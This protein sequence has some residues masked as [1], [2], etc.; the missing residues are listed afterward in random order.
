MDIK[1]MIYYAVASFVLIL[2]SI[3]VLIYVLSYRKRNPA[4]ESELDKATISILEKGNLPLLEKRIEVLVNQIREEAHGLWAAL[5][6][7]NAVIATVFSLF[8][9][10]QLSQHV[11]IFI[12]SLA[13]IL[14]ALCSSYLLIRNYKES[15]SWIESIKQSLRSYIETEKITRRDIKNI[16][17]R[18]IPGQIALSAKYAIGLVYIEA[19]LVAMIY[20]VS[21]LIQ[22]STRIP[23]YIVD[24][25]VSALSTKSS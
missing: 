21:A 14:C 23:Q 7:I 12:F 25:N 20:M 3:L 13:I 24:Q 18:G 5:L 2:S 19:I 6:T 16:F 10:N 17:S 4:P 8:S 15:R 9:L 1:I 11:L 22:F